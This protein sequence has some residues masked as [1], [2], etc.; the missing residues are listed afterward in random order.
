MICLSFFFSHTRCWMLYPGN[1]GRVT[2]RALAGSRNTRRTH[3]CPCLPDGGY[4]HTHTSVPSCP[5]PLCRNVSIIG[6]YSAGAQQPRQGCGRRSVLSTAD[7]VTYV[8]D[9]QFF[10]LFFPCLTEICINI[11]L[12]YPD[13]LEAVYSE[14]P[15]RMLT[16]Y[17][18]G[19]LVCL[20]FL[21]E[22]C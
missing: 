21:K 4:A 2:T 11:Y 16:E 13:R 7:T 9:I 14:R 20:F 12:V 3:A 1:F 8:I 18:L 10:S 17:F 15:A 22:V 6:G 19:F 5:A